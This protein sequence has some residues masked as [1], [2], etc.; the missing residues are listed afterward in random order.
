MLKSKAFYPE[1]VISVKI[2]SLDGQPNK[3]NSPFQAMRNLAS[4]NK[5]DSYWARRTPKLV[6]WTP[7]TWTHVLIY[8]MTESI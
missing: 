4:Q 3:T 7:L 6:L 8:E 2:L 5:V 1:L